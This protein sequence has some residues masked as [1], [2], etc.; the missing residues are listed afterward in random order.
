MQTILGSGGVIGIE[1]AKALKE[2][3]SENKD[4]GVKSSFLTDLGRV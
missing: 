3:T 1:L 4:I 2:F